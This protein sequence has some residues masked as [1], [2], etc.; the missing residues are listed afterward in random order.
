MIYFSSIMFNKH[1]CFVPIYFQYFCLPSCWETDCMHCMVEP[2]SPQQEI[3]RRLPDS[4]KFMYFIFS[5]FEIMPRQL[6]L[7]PSH[8]V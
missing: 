7:F 8:V 3:K 6:S 2:L 4:A 5:T 1:V